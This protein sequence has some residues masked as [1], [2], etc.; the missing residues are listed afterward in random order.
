M[1]APATDSARQRLSLA[2]VLS[3]VLLS[4][5]PAQQSEKFDADVGRASLKGYSSDRMVLAVELSLTSHENVTVR[6]LSFSG[7]TLGGVPFYAAPFS[8]P[9]SLPAGKPVSL[10]QPV[11]L[12]VFYRDLDTLKPVQAALDS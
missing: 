5:A 7:L 2:L 11:E 3:L 1:D 6:Q 9:I 4:T 12:S 8:G 10:R